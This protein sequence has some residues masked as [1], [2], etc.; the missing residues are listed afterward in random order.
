M[1]EIEVGDT[2]TWKPPNDYETFYVVLAKHGGFLWLLT[3]QG[4]VSTLRAEFMQKVEPTFEVGKT[5]VA[6]GDISFFTV[7]A[8]D[9]KYA[10]AR[11]AQGWPTWALVSKRSEYNEVGSGGAVSG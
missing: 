3:A 10:Y 7:K 6:K 9:D 2:V 11:S 1:S 8:V 4:G 5:Y